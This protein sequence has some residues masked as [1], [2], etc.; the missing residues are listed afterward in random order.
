[1][2][3]KKTTNKFKIIYKTIN[4]PDDQHD[5]FRKQGLDFLKQKFKKTTDDFIKDTYPKKDMQI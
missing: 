3:N 5:G 2:I 4:M 1:M